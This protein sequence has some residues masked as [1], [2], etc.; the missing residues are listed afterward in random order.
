MLETQVFY[1]EQMKV[2]FPLKSS[3]QGNDTSNYRENKSVFQ[4][5]LGNVRSITITGS[6]ENT[7]QLWKMSSP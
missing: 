5:P 3:A 4:S 7:I 1:L 2:V 6:T